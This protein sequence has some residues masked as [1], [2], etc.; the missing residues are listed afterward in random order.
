MTLRSGLGAQSL[1]TGG[2]GTHDLFKTYRQG[3]SICHIGAVS[4]FRRTSREKFGS[5]PAPGWRLLPLFLFY[6]LPQRFER[7]DIL[8][9]ASRRSA[10]FHLAK[11][12]LEFRCGT[13]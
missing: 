3:S 12:P 6:F 9:T 13:P 5:R 10:F 7:I 2:E 1:E 8:D 4:N 11:P